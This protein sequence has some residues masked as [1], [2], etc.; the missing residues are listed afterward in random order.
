M[1]RSRRKTPICGIT[2]A[3]SEKRDKQIAN[4]RYRRAATVAVSSGDD[5]PLYNSI[6]NPW[7]FSKDG[8]QY[9]PK[10]SNCYDEIMRK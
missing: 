2:V 6:I 1:S 4:R 8:K 3:E 9:I 5:P 7:A 10:N